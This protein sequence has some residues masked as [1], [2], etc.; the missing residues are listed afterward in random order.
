FNNLTTCLHTKTGLALL[1]DEHTSN[2]YDV[3]L[4]L[5]KE[6][7]IIQKQD[8]VCVSGGDSHLNVSTESLPS[9]GS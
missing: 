3:R 7:L 2:T 6:L 8:V 4:K 5:M 9:T 1:Y